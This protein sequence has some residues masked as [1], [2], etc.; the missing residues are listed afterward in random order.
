[1]ILGNAS[2]G[3]ITETGQIDDTVLFN[4]PSRLD[5]NLVSKDVAAGNAG[6]QL[7]LFQALSLAKYSTFPSCQQTLQLVK[8][9]I[10]PHCARHSAP[11]Q[12]IT[13]KLRTIQG[14]QSRGGWLCSKSVQRFRNPD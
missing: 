4:T 13:T 6:T 8:L 11:P 1:M 7:P 5:T 12:D 10:T 9:R 14:V 3:K 2:Q